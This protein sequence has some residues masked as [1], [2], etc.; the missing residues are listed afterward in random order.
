MSDELNL[1]PELTLDPSG[2]AAQAAAA[3]ELTLEPTAA[4]AAPELTLEPTAPQAPQPDAAAIQAQRDANAVK[5]DES[6][7][8]D[9]EKKMVD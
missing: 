1:T 7:L 8:S 2:A 4:Q 5:L 3:P 9:A 6:M